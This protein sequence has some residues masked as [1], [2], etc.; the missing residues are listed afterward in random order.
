[1]KFKI[2]IFF[3]LIIITYSVIPNWDIAKSAINLISGSNGQHEYIIDKRN[4]WYSSSELLKKTIKKENGKIT[5]IENTFTL[6]GLN[7]NTNDIKYSGT[8][9]F[10]AIESFYGDTNSKTGIPIICP[11]GTYHPFKVNSINSKTEYSYSTIQK[12]TKFDLKCYFHRSQGGHFL[13]YYLMN[14]NNYLLELGTSNLSGKSGY[15]FDVD[16]IYDFKILNRDNF[17]VTDT[18]TYPFMGL[19]KKDKKIRLIGTTIDFSSNSQS[20]DNYKDLLTA[21][22]YTQ[23][24]FH[25]Y[26]FINDF[27]YFTYN[28][29]SDF[30]SGYS[31]KS[32]AFI[33]NKPAYDKITSVTFKNNENSPFE[34][35]NDVEIIEMENI[36]NYRYVYYKLK[37]KVTNVYYHGVYDIISDLIVFHTDEEVKLFIPYIELVETDKGNYQHANSMLLITETNAYKICAIKNSAGTDC[38]EECE[39]GKLVLDIEGNK[40]TTN[41]LCDSGK[42]LLLPHR[43]CTKTCNDSIYTSNSTHCG[44]CR[45]LDAN[46]KYRFI[47]GTKCLNTIPSNAKVNKSELYLLECDSGYILNGDTCVIHCYNTCETCYEYSENSKK[48]RCK[49]CKEGYYLADKI[50]Y[51]CELI[52]PTTI[53]TTIP[54]TIITTIPTTII[55]TIP[56]TI[57][58]TIPTTI[59]TTIPT[60]IFTTIPTTIIT[61][62][63]TTVFTNIPTTT[64][65]TIPT[66]IFTTIPK[67]TITNAPTTIITTIPT[68]IF[69]TIPT[70]IVTTIPTTIEESPTTI[71]QEMPSTIVE[72]QCKYGILINYTNAYSNLSNEEIYNISKDEIIKTYCKYGSKVTIQGNIGFNFEVT[73]TIKD[74]YNLE[75]GFNANSINL[76]EC[77]AILKE[78]YKIDKNESLILLKL[79]YGENTGANKTFQ[80]ELYHPITRQKLNLSYCDNT[81]ANVY[82]PFEIGDKQ[83]EI[84]NDLVDQ[85]YD[86]LDLN[87]IFYREICTPYKSENGTDVLLD[88]RE[89]FV[90]SSL[91]N[92]SLC[93][94]GCNYSDFSLYHKYIKC[95]C[96][97]NNSDIVTL[98]IKHLSGNNLA[99]SF[100]STLKI[101]NWKPMICYNLVFNFKIFCHNYGSILTLIL[102]GAYLVAMIYYCAKEINPLRVEVSKMLFEDQNYD[103]QVAEIKKY[104]GDKISTNTTFQNKTVKSRKSKKSD[105]PKNSERIDIKIHYPPKRVSISNKRE[106]IN[107]MINQKKELSSSSKLALKNSK[108][109]LSELNKPDIKINNKITSNKKNSKVLKP[110]PK[111]IEEKIIKKEKSIK[112]ENDDNINPLFFDNF[113][114]NNL[115]YEEACKYDQRTCCRTYYSVMMREHIVLLTFFSWG[116]HNLFYIKFAKFLI[117]FCIDMSM[118]ALFFVHESMHKKYTEGED[119][120]FIEKIPQY[121]FTL[122]VA[123]VFEV[124]LCYLSMIDTHYYQIKH[125]SLEEK[126]GN[127]KIVN[128]MECVKKKLIGFLIMTLILF[129]F[130]WYFISAF[131]AV[132]QNTQIIFLKDSF[133]TFGMSFIEP[134]L[135]Y[136]FTMILRCISLS[137]LCKKRC[138]C[139][140]VFKI[141]DLIPLF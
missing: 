41:G 129:L 82:V 48:Q 139:G 62:I 64:I 126:N 102:F 10:E 20:V 68:T 109:N 95:E 101:T 69:T 55:T 87:D 14:G 74:I 71:M 24:S 66:T 2:F 61:T 4:Y 5:S 133:V 97:A 100:L 92:V 16:E 27:Y 99:Q 9:E 138:C 11:W 98:D 131:C 58:T 37:D 28:N 45:D 32:I 38:L 75:K 50:N 56:T 57:F 21:K 40:C 130:F 112:E 34:F 31:T 80:Y 91:V 136:G 125:L 3:T 6:Y 12:S 132:Y 36:F 43:I 30:E 118:N 108:R 93:P 77:E 121:A 81:T 65:T 88:D 39:S 89:E 29:I 23:A 84:Y 117:I 15:Q 1:M 111:P 60:T 52:P 114:L 115:E 76:T 106:K 78:V 86:P 113:E 44:L 134:F 19:V 8:V 13:V 140:C 119:F 103:A 17:D 79:L 63:P 47:N 141:S 49:T 137:K 124:I 105:N 90:Y 73:T 104:S 67:A 7:W 94:S 120:T 33:D 35:L 83:I 22:K 85:G 54:T 53:I 18:I 128:I 26:H 110:K 51:N 107:N 46:N 116:D 123:R 96:G 59:I 135:T 25:V 122:I 42:K 70:T 72:E 127:E